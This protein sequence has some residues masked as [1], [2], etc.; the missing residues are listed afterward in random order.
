MA[1]SIANGKDPFQARRKSL[2]DVLRR[3][4]PIIEIVNDRI[5]F[6]HFTAKE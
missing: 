1:L 6:V 5:S 3:C 2:L 4:G